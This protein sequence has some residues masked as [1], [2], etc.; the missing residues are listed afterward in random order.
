M[1]MLCVG[2]GHDI[3]REQVLGFG[4]GLP[5]SP[6][7]MR[8]QRSE[9]RGNPAGC[10][11]R[12]PRCLIGFDRDVDADFVADLSRGLV[13]SR[14][15]VSPIRC[16]LTDSCVPDSGIMVSILRFLLW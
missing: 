5:Y 11:N 4:R 16:V 2:S 9:E 15:R 14:A 3:S 12:E 7:L 8:L 10:G 1:L 6:V 13:R